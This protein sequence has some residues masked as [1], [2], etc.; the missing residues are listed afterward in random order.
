METVINHTIIEQLNWRYAVKKFDST[1]KISNRDLQTLE[2]SLRLAPSSYGLQPW[3]FFIVQSPDLRKRLASASWNQP[4]IE[5][6]SHL[7]V[8]TH[9]KEMTEEYIDKYVH[10]IS[11]IRGIPEN[12]LQPFRDLMINKVTTGPLALNQSNWTARQA[13][14]AV[15]S[16]LTVAALLKID[17]CPMEGII[18]EQYD[19]ILGLT[20]SPY[21]TIAVLAVGYRAED[22]KTQFAKK[23]RFDLNDVISV[24]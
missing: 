14:L 2:E 3:K 16:F 9:L 5:D 4:Q 19:Q 21:G 18:P 15:G 17:V 24:V 10:T 12:E 8:V 1:R 6:A 20:D 11:N 22:D 7:V 13:Y 23:V